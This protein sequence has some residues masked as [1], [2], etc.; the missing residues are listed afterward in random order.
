MKHLLFALKFSLAISFAI[1]LLI[2]IINFFHE[3]RHT[4]VKVCEVELSISNES[5][6]VLHT[7]ID[8]ET[9]HEK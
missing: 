8:K 7:Y 9:C 1:S 4:E 5:N 3:E 2:Y 6:K